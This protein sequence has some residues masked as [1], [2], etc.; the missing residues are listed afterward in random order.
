MPTKPQTQQPNPDD[1]L[2]HITAAGP[3]K[4]DDLQSS[5]DAKYDS[6]STSISAHSSCLHNINLQLAKLEKSPSSLELPSVLG[7]IH[8]LASSSSQLPL[9]PENFSTK[10]PKITLS[11]F[12]GTNPLDG[13]F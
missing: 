3:A 9:P 1:F 13:L 10:P 4:F 12:D 2:A 7:S 11:I 6:L 8:T 5:L